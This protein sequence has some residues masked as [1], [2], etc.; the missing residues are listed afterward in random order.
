MR[1][2]AGVRPKKQRLLLSPRVQG[3]GATH[4]APPPVDKDRGS[5]RFISQPEPVPLPGLFFTRR[6]TCRER[7]RLPGAGRPAETGKPGPRAPG[8]A[9]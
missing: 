7:G 9:E 2:G 8:P 1:P 6:R 4:Q 5:S 3:N